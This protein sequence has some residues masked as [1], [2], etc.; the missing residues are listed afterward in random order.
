[1][2]SWRPFSGSAADPATATL[3]PAPA[4]E[5]A[6]ATAASPG[7][8]PRDLLLW[9]IIGAISTLGWLLTLGYLV[10]SR[11]KP[12]SDRQPAAENPSE[13]R[14]FKRLLAACASSSALHARHAIIEWASIMFPQASVVSLS[15]VTTVFDDRPLQAELDRLNTSL[16]SPGGASW[17]GSAL[18][19]VVQGL[20][21]RH[22]ASGNEEHS[23]Q[24]YPQGA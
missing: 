4:I 19:D 15:Q 11:R 17:D 7:A 18:T 21:K 16:Y 8:A 24:L 9:Q 6:T 3:I 12:D 13:K 2:I 23:L 5:I 1:M 20:R 10:W 14:A 22:K